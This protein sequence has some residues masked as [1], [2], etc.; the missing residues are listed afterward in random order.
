MT[1][2]YGFA[3]ECCLEAGQRICRQVP[4]LRSDS[5]QPTEHDCARKRK[6]CGSGYEDDLESLGNKSCD[7]PKKKGIPRTAHEFTYKLMFAD[8]LQKGSQF[9]LQS[10]CNNDNVVST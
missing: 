2:W 10:L 5:A 8:R 4:N 3:E 9:Y 7:L 1:K 6:R